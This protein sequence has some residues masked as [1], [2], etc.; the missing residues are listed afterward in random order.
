MTDISTEWTFAVRQMHFYAL[1][2]QPS[3]CA[4]FTHTGYLTPR[5]D[6]KRQNTALFYSVRL[7]VIHFGLLQGGGS[8]FLLLVQEKPQA[9]Q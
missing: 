2:L 3:H 7:G 9:Q 4:P 5:Q 6:V 8:L 1:R